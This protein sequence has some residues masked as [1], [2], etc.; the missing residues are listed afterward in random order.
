VES[1]AGEVLYQ[2]KPILKNTLGASPATL[3]LVQKGLFGVVN[4]DGGTG[5]ASRLPY[6]EVAGKT[7]TSQVVSLEKE[8]LRGKTQ[9]RYENHAWFVAYA[10]ASNPQV[11]L[12]VL[13][14][15]GGHG[16]SAAA[17][18]A[19]RLLA[20]LFP[21]KPLDAVAAIQGQN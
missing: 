16:G 14:E 7:G 21:E 4:E 11:A 9:A 8:K 6:V 13:V 15:H 2:E 20:V 1:P 10:P 17:P 3:A 5:R 19:H 12:A 18:L